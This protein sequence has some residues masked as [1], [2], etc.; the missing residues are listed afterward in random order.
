MVKRFCDCCGKE[1]KN[2]VYNF[3]YLCHLDPSRKWNDY[4]EK[5]EPVSSR[6][7]HKDLC[8]YCYNRIFSTAMQKYVELSKTATQQTLCSSDDKVSTPKST[9]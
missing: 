5:G 9:S 3:D 6:E 2:R 7:E 1:I 8:L 4:Q